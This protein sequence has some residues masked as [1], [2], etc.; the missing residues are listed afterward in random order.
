M[1]NPNANTGETGDRVKIYP[2]YADYEAI[3][4][5]NEYV[6]TAEMFQRVY[7]TNWDENVFEY[8]YTINGEDYLWDGLLEFSNL[9]LDPEF[10]EQEELSK[11]KLHSVSLDFQAKAFIFE[12]M[13]VEKADG[14]VLEMIYSGNLEDT[15]NTQSFDYDSITQKLVPL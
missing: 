14:A 6:K 15:E 3:F 10:Q 4:W 2:F 1:N 12:G 11:S 8:K 9:E 13:A 5:S 7:K